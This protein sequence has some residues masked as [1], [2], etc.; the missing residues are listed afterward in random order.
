MISIDIGGGFSCPEC[1]GEADVYYSAKTGERMCWM[2]K[3][4]GRKGYW[5]M[6]RVVMMA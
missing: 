6:E 1:S 5:I 4:C 2:C 3:A